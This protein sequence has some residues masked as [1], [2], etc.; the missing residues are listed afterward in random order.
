MPAFLL[1]NGEQA[2]MDKLRHLRIL[3]LELA[4][5]RDIPGRRFLSI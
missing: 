5:Y 4:L 2:V 1:A 3:E